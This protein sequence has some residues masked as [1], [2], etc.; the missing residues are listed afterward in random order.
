MKVHE[1]LNEPSK[2]TTHAYVRDE[3]DQCLDNEGVW[4][5]NAAKWCLEGAIERCYGSDNKLRIF[6]RIF[7]ETCR[8]PIAF[9]DTHSYEEVIKLCKKLDI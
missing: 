4:A 5:P 1:L 8:S 9:N 7:L 3:Y 2:W 6:R